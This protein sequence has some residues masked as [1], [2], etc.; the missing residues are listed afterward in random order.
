MNGKNPSNIKEILNSKNLYG[1]KL[2]NK[3]GE[4]YDNKFRKIKD[5][6]SKNIDSGR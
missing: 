5:C 1:D 4:K 3:I 6:M 2:Y